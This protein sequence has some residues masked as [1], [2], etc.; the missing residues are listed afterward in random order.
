VSAFTTTLHTRAGRS[1]A[2]L[3]TTG[4]LA[5][6]G[7]FLAPGAALAGTPTTVDFS[8]AGA[9]Q[10]W[11]VPTRRHVRDLHPGRRLGRSG[12]GPRLP[13]RRRQGRRTRRHPP[14]DH[15]WLH[16]AIGVGRIQNDD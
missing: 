2:A 16:G 3:T 8:C 13:R 15:A 5:A 11:T 4:L 9:A 14:G 10:T 12:R 1:L 6:A 7:A